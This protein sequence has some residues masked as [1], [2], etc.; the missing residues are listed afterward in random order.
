MILR[1][2][3]RE[4][5]RER[6]RSVLRRNGSISFILYRAIVITLQDQMIFGG[7][8]GSA[9]LLKWKL[10]LKQRLSSPH[11]ISVSDVQLKFMSCCSNLWLILA[12]SITNGICVWFN[13]FFFLL[14]CLDR[15]RM[16]LFFHLLIFISI[17]YSNKNPS[18]CIHVDSNDD[19]FRFIFL[20]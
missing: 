7:I 5:V 1:F 2:L 6:E 14:S 16:L 12:C 15:N 10:M 3:C 11:I 9:A 18:E 20:S 19:F 4:S 8:Q 13:E 17:C